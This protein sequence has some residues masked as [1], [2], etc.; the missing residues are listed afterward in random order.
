MKQPFISE[1]FAS[2]I[3]AASLLSAPAHAQNMAADLLPPQ[4][5]AAIVASMGMRPLDR[6]LWRNGRYVLRAVDRY[7]RDVR[8]V[9]DARD[10]QVL[11]V[12]PLARGY[13]HRDDG[14]D[15]GPRYAPPRDY[16]R[17]DRYD[18][19]FDAPSSPPPAAIPGRPRID[20]DD[21]FFD[22]DRQE[23]SLVPRAEPPSVISAPR[24]PAD[25]SPP[26]R[27][28]SAAPVEPAPAKTP[29]PR[30]RP[31][32]ATAPADA[33]PTGSVRPQKAPAVAK[34]KKS[35]TPKEAS[36]QPAKPEAKKDIRIIDMSK[37]K[38]AAAPEEK[39]GEAIRF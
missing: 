29:L 35:E 10:G 24:E 2:G 19:R 8:V 30:P 23:G 12:R 20:D 25:R 36:A 13:G 11:A 22:D 5:V 4:E 26:R 18:P 7:G 1:I 27:T 37:P 32:V 15:A 16:P 6:P 14:Y 28:V 3:I 9:L 33:Q 31:E 21:E 17:S 39:P 38:A 34:D